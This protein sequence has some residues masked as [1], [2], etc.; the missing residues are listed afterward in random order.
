MA[1]ILDVSRSGYYCYCKKKISQ[2]QQTNERLLEMIKQVY[3]Q[4][5]GTYGNPNRIQAELM[6]PGQKCSRPSCSKTDEASR[7]CS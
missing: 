5:R 4:S 7:Y 1:E 3:K 6:A 2:R